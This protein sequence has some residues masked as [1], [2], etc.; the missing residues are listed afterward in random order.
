[1]KKIPIIFSTLLLISACSNNSNFY[2][3]N[4]KN[5]N[6]DIISNKENKYFIDVSF[7]KSKYFLNIFKQDNFQ[8]SF[9]L[10]GKEEQLI[11]VKNDYFFDFPIKDKGGNYVSG[12]F[13]SFK[14]SSTE[15]KKLI[16]ELYFYD[17]DKYNF[18]KNLKDD[19]YLPILRKEKYI[20]NFDSNYSTQKS[21]TVHDGND[22][23]KIILKICKINY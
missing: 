5:C 18:Q 19:V 8:A 12:M 23:Y 21:L 4:N 17:T 22:D 16:G 13:T 20:I 1:M 11:N 7:Y 14:I 2:P 10:N 15:N 3:Q 9:I 6:E